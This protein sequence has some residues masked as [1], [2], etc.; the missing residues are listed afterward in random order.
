LLLLIA[1]FAA[2]AGLQ[3]WMHK[4]VTAAMKNGAFL[5]AVEFEIGARGFKSRRL[6]SET[7]NQWSIVN[8]VTH[9]SDH[10]FMWIDAFS[11]YVLPARDLPAGMTPATGAAVLQEFKAAAP[12]VPVESTATLASAELSETGVTSEFVRPLAAA[13]ANGGAGTSSAGSTA[14]LGAC[15]RRATVRSRRHDPAVGRS[16]SRAL[17]GLDRLNY[18]GDV[19]LFVYGIAENAAQVLGVLFIAWVI[20]RLSRPRLELRRGLLLTAGFLPMFVGAMWFAGILPR[21]GTIAVGVLIAAWGDRYLR[22]G[23]RSMTG[24]TQ[25]IAVPAALVGTVLLVYLSSQMYYAPGLWMEREANPEEAAATQRDNEQLIFEQSARL[26]ADIENLAPR[27]AD[28]AN[29]FFV[30]FA[31]YGGQRVF[32][33]EIGLA[34]KRIGERYGATQRSLLLINEPRDFEKHPLATAAALRHALNTLAKRMDVDEDVLFLSLSS[35]GGEDATISVSSELGYWRDLGAN[36][37]AGMLKE[38]G[39]R[40]R[41]IVISACHSGSFISALRDENTIILTAAAADRASFGCSDDNDLTYFGEAFYRDALPQ[42][43]TLRAAFEA[44]RV[45]IERREKV[46]GRTPS[47][48]QAHFGAALEKKLSALETARIAAHTAAP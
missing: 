24:T 22:A 16:F 48:P 10:L 17:A 30:G 45:D 41:V 21:I 28:R 25:N 1:V 9:T 35:H 11:A 23:L 2:F 32:A 19:D 13:A 42:A 7:F 31:G 15:R 6:N 33:Q 34:A 39:I 46:E 5:G 44:A 36:D 18:D 26:N 8:D 20:S 47:A 4:R 38:S 12:A 3:R 29:A 40:W 14:H 43:A 37:L 27:I